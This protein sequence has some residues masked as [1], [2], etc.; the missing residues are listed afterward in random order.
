MSKVANSDDHKGGGG[1]APPNPFS[2]PNPPE[3]LGCVSAMPWTT[4]GAFGLRTQPPVIL[5]YDLRAFWH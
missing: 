3:L 5:A 2:I 1:R 4:K